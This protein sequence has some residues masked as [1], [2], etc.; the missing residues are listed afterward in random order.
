MRRIRN[1]DDQGGMM[2]V[3]KK[4]EHRNIFKF[5]WLSFNWVFCSH[6]VLHTGR[7]R[8]SG[9]CYR[10][11]LPVNG[12]VRFIHGSAEQCNLMNGP[13]RELVNRQRCYF[14][15]GYCNTRG[16][17]LTVAFNESQLKE[18]TSPYPAPSLHWSMFAEYSKTDIFWPE[19]R[20]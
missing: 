13:K 12:P 16:K 10:V 19:R 15:P 3:L 2:Y 1:A 14:S 8:G 17:R 6:G 9:R 11:S 18:F 7:F 5:R 4:Y 20:A